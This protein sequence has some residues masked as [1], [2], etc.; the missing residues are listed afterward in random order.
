MDKD[1]MNLLSITARNLNYQDF[2]ENDCL[3]YSMGV[4]SVQDVQTL[5]TYINKL[6]QEIKF[7]TN[8]FRIEE[9]DEDHVKVHCN[10]SYICTLNHDDGWEEMER[11]KNIVIKI[12]D[13]IGAEIRE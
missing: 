9:L 2:I 13:I 12:A 1:T 7:E 4:Q 10:D 8:I 11:I 3:E 5:L 6:E